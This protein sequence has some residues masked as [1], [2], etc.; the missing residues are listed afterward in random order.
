MQTGSKRTAGRARGPRGTI[1]A[2]RTRRRG[3]PRK[4]KGNPQAGRSARTPNGRR[5]TRTAATKSSGTQDQGRR[6]SRRDACTSSQRKHRS[7]AQAITND[8]HARKLGGG[9]EGVGRRIRKGGAE[10][11]PQTPKACG[12]P[13]DTDISGEPDG[14][15][16]AR[17]ITDYLQK[18]KVPRS[19][20]PLKR[21]GEASTAFL[22]GINRRRCQQSKASLANYFFWERNQT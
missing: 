13:S 15:G 3:T 22:H 2:G 1:S 17:R 20:P 10:C 16:E 12:G 18:L 11:Q 9:R 21:K 5:L 19:P 4:P 7:N 14:R 6:N 8:N